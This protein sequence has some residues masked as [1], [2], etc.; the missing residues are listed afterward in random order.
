MGERELSATYRGVSSVVVGYGFL[1][2]SDEFAHA[3]DAASCEPAALSQPENEMRV[4]RD[5]VTER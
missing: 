4:F 3:I 1:C 2:C 5:A